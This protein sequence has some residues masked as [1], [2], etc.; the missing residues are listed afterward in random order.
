MHGRHRVA[1]HDALAASRAATARLRADAA[2]VAH[3]QV[4]GVEEYKL[5]FSSV[6]DGD[7]RSL[8][9]RE[10]ELWNAGDREGWLACLDLHRLNIQAPGG[11][12]LTGREAAESIWSTWHDAFPDN[13]IETTSIHADDRGGVHEGRFTGTHTGMLRGPAGELAPTGRH[14]DG[15][16]AASTSSRRARSAASTCTSTR[17]TC[18]PSSASH[19]WPASGLL[20][21]SH[22]D[23]VVE[24]RSSQRLSAARAASSTTARS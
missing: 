19:Q 13:R 16:S 3:V 1:G 23:F 7:T 15:R 12:R 17:W 24:T 11:M 2:A 5:V 10:I 18:S 14:V 9:E 22:R 21:H 4:R 20:R 6:R 8:I